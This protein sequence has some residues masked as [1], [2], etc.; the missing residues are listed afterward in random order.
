MFAGVALLVATLSINNTFSIVVAQRTRES[1]LLRAIGASRRQV[2]GSVLV[3]AVVV[4]IVAS[5][6]GLAAGVG[7]ALGLDALI[8]ATATELPG[9]SLVITSGTVVA[10]FATGVF[11][12]VVASLAPALRASRVP[13]LAALRDVAV[14]RSSASWWRAGAGILSSTAGIVLTLTGISGSGALSRA[15]LGALLMVCGL[16]L[17]GPVAARPAG[18]VMGGVIAATRGVTGSL[19]RRNAMRNPRRTAGTATALMVG[20]SVVTLF[21][22]LAASIKASVEDDVTGSFRGDLVIEATSW[23]GTGLSPAL[24]DDLAALPEVAATGRLAF[25]P[26]TIDGAETGVSVAEPAGIAALFDTEM[27]GGTLAGLTDRQ[28]AVSEK[29]AQGEGWQVGTPVEVGY[30]DGTTSAMTIGAVCVDRAIL[31]DVLLPV[32]AWT[33]H[34]TQRSDLMVFV[35]LAGGVSLESGRVAVDEVADRH[36]APAAL[37]RDEFIDGQAAEIDQL[38]AV[39]YALLILAIV[40]ALGGIANTLALSVHERT[41]ELGLLRAVGQTRP[42]LR[43]MVRWEGVIVAVFGT[44]GGIGLGLFL[45]WRL[46]A[47]VAAVEG[48][49]T[50]TVPTAQ[51]VVVAVAG[52]GAGMLAAVRPARRAARLD[53]LAAL[54]HD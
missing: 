54:A 45:G 46:V 21:T 6:V 10:A 16:V 15:A 35:D 32:A 34:A 22:V 39:I 8:A 44:A 4:G 38:L 36:A 41:R 3:E 47:A 12:T 29:R 33:P 37:D 26:V 1:A 40:I 19:A 20:V 17:L 42:Q 48:L 31:D 14:D 52:A 25:A 28:L 2:L 43:A 53:L 18:A 9:D 23:S 30:A 27:A 5:G 7:I 50:L 49:G 24:A 51:L 13:S 11:V